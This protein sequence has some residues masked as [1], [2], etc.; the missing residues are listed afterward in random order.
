VTGHKRLA[1]VDLYTAKANQTHLADAAFV[2][3]IE[4]EHRK[5][6]GKLD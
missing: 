6:T 4:A 1:D 3:Q 2:K 5:P